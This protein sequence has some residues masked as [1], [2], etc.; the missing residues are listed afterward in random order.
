ML[1]MNLCTKQKESHT[2]KTNSWLPKGEGG[3]LIYIYT[4]LYK[5]DKQGP[6]V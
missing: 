6:T 2:Q 3:R 5:M 1:Q 4:A